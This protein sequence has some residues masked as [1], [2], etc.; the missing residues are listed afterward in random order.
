[1]LSFKVKWLFPLLAFQGYLTLS[2]IL[3]FFGPWDWGGDNRF[4][5]FLY[6]TVSQ[7]F[8]AVGYFIGW[9]RV[10]RCESFCVDFRS[11]RYFDRCLFFSIVLAV[12]TSLSRTGSLF[13]DIVTGLTNTGFAYNENFERLEY[14]NPYLVVEYL[15]ILFSVFLVSVYPMMIVY[16]GRLNLYRRLLSLFVVLTTVFTYVATGTNKGVADLVITAP[17]LMILA[18]WSGNSDFKVSKKVFFSIFSFLFFAFLLFFGAGQKQREGGVGEYGIFN[19]GSYILEANRE[20]GISLILSDKYLVIY[21]SLTRYLGQG[22]YALSM[23]FDLESSS[24]YGFGA[25]MFFARNINSILGTD[26]FTAESIPGVLERET[27]WGMMTLWHSIY[28]WLASDFGFVGALFVL[29]LFSYI[30]SVS[31]GLSL[32]NQGHLWVVMLYFMLILFFYI[33]A[34]NQIFQSAETAVAFLMLFCW[35][36]LFGSPRFI[37]RF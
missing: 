33:P 1:M 23:S 26:Y 21:E 2:Q 22:Y 36:F 24:T 12:P 18:V 6:L 17:V 29:G 13:P 16:W 20:S 10:N 35:L 3:F 37:L 15:R 19:T 34:N 30:L 27:G 8:I 7:V 32:K 28:P 14:G 31:W 25:S 11:I 5:L 9:R 4:K